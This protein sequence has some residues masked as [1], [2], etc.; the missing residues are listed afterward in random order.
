M[1]HDKM[2]TEDTENSVLIFNDQFP[3]QNRNID[4]KK[5]GNYE[6]V[7]YVHNKD[8]TW[9]VYLISRVSNNRNLVL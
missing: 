8:K 2:K 4:T 5:Q 3:L 9:F 6:Y 1:S 7:K